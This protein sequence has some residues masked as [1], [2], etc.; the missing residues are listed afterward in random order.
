[1]DGQTMIHLTINDR[2]VE[3]RQG[4]TILEIARA[5]GIDIPTL[6][7]HPKLS[8]VGACRM[9]LVEVQ[10]NPKWQ[11]SCS[12]PAQEGMVV[13]TDSEA[14]RDYRRLNLEFLFSERNHICP[15][16]ESSGACELQ[17]LGYRH[18][19]ESIRVEYLAPQLSTE[20]S[21][22]YFGLDHNRCILCTRCIRVC[23]EFEGV[24]T[25][26]LI[27]RGGKTRIGVDMHGEFKNSSCT[28]C[29][30]CV[31]VCPTGAL[32]DKMPAYRGRPQ[33]LTA[34]ATTCPG[35]SV[36]CG[37]IAET[38]Y[39]QVVRVIGDESCTVNRGHTCQL[40]RYE[41]VDCT[42]P[43]LDRPRV[44]G[45]RNGPEWNL[46]LDLCRTYLE[47]GQPKKTV[48]ALPSRATLEA[49]LETEALLNA[50]GDQA[51]ATLLDV[52]TM[53]F[54]KPIASFEDIQQADVIW[55]VD[56]DPA[57]YWPVLASMIRRRIRGRSVRLVICNSRPTE[58]DRHADLV[59]DLSPEKA[60]TLISEGLSGDIELFNTL[61][62]E[63]Q[64]ATL[65]ACLNPALSHLVLTSNQP[66]R[67]GR[68]RD[69]PKERFA[70]LT[71]VKVQFV[72]LTA[73]TNTL[74]ITGI[75]GDRL[76]NRRTL[77]TESIGLLIAVPADL[78]SE[79]VWLSVRDLAA[80][81]ERTIVLAAYE[82]DEDIQAEL[83][84]P[85]TTWWEEGPGHTVNLSGEIHAVNPVLPPR[86]S[87]LPLAQAIHRLSETLCP[88]TFKAIPESDRDPI[89][90]QNRLAREWKVG[91][92]N[93][94]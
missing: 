43:R 68:R 26:D 53:D 41:S 45:A 10:G 35:C 75:L 57:K 50:L 15:F 30:A 80:L 58:L 11:A 24:H 94:G 87:A 92:E 55:I 81:A 49:C 42:H 85:V 27:G 54:P 82:M 29:G 76:V 72:D 3:G 6:C 20:L 83:M 28:Y 47:Y 40:G 1:M 84:L 66:D 37:L 59:L 34:K 79:A 7:Y 44:R 21:S 63:R 13:R 93:A 32:Y 17:T 51:V 33:D 52:E 48:V 39:D 9:C 5:A 19:M 56:C 4:Q 61:S 12:T 18:Q 36:G 14:L 38:R 74:G 31:Q 67:H 89:A 70:A 88:Q 62:E 25:L 65:R 69:F 46:A 60:S 16:C 23:D 64:R 73:G 71:G 91:K 90:M 78:T 86:G 2:T 8:I 22:P 77:F